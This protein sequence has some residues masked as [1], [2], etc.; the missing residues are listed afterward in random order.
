MSIPL[1]AINRLLRVPAE[2]IH[3]IMPKLCLKPNY[4]QVLGELSRQVSTGSTP[5]N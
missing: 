1:I 3:N 5:G 4:K 2:L